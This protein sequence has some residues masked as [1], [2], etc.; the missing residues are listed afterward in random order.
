M[1]VLTTR[2]EDSAQ[3]TIDAFKEASFEVKNIPMIETRPTVHLLNLKKP[4]Y[5]IEDKDCVIIS[6][7]RGAKYFIEYYKPQD[8][9]G[10][11]LAAIGPAT[12][13]VLKD[14]GF[15]VII[16][17]DSYD[18]EGLLNMLVHRPAIIKVLYFGAAD[19]RD[20]LIVAL[21]TLGRDVTD[22]GAYRTVCTGQ[23]QVEI[24]KG[25]LWADVVAF[26]SPSAVKC[27]SKKLGGPEGLVEALKE[28]RI[29]AIGHVTRK[30]LIKQGVNNIITPKR[31]TLNSVI[32][33]LQE[34]QEM[35]DGTD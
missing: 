26:F 1:K 31:H 30:A 32:E 13:Q 18:Q 9:T 25:I 14:A 5:L 19:K 33:R 7:P 17:N 6:S 34:I 20:D 22:F 23:S 27:M 35:K 12:A 21:Q 16:P 28:K 29:I 4:E 3:R 15:E 2:P 10:K 11:V 24:L 8:L